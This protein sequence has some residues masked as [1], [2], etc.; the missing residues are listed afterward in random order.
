MSLVKRWAHGIGSMTP[1]AAGFP[2]LGAADIAYLDQ[3]EQ[4]AMD[5]NW[6]AAQTIFGAI[7]IGTGGA[8]ALVSSTAKW[9]VLGTVVSIAVTSG[10][11]GYGST[12]TVTISGGGGFGATA[13]ATVSLGA[14]VLITVT[15]G[16]YGY[17]SAPTV[18]FSS[19]AATATASI[20][21]AQTG[22]GGRFQCGHGD[23]PIISGN[24]QHFLNAGEMF[25]CLSKIVQIA[26]PIPT[27]T[28]NWIWA[29]DPG[30]SIYSGTA[31][32]TLAFGAAIVPLTR[33]YDGAVNPTFD[34][35]FLVGAGAG[36]TTLPTDGKYPAVAVFQYDP[37]L[38]IVTCI[39]SGWN[40]FPTP[41]TLADYQNSG[42]ANFIQVTCPVTVN[43][44]QYLYFLAI[45]DES[46]DGENLATIAA[47]QWTGIGISYDPTS[48]RFQ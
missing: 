38:N 27:N 3:N 44:D 47:N 5:K 24:W 34:V 12:P 25:S 37:F 26:W 33:I 29:L 23:F 32:A 21:G 45:L 11:S 43:V 8:F 14:V 20:L 16:G 15:N 48:M 7:T 22:T 18:S 42:A 30:G 31:T 13:V 4:Q 2:Q 40:Y 6:A 28:L 35:F 1:S 46:Y 17:T 19:G 36:R 9:V 10:G 41:A 39:S